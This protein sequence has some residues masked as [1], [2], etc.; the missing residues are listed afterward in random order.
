VYIEDRMAYVVSMQHG[1]PDTKTLPSSW[2]II[3]QWSEDESCW[4]NC[5]IDGCNFHGS[6]YRGLGGPY[7]GC[8]NFDCFGGRDINLVYYDKGG[9]TWGTPLDWTSIERS[10]TDPGIH[11]YPNPASDFVIVHSDR[12]APESVVIYDLAGKLIQQEHCSSTTHRIDLS[13]FSQ[14][15]YILVVRSEAGTLQEKIVIDPH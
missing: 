3:W 6:Y 2:G 7:G 12:V 1:N 4:D 13:A 10:T 5:C 9:E 8:G 15:I 14:G 11:V